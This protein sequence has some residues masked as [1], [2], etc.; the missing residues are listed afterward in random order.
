MQ[1]HQTYACAV[2][3]RVDQVVWI[4]RVFMFFFYFFGQLCFYSSQRN[5]RS[6]TFAQFFRISCSIFGTNRDWRR[7]LVNDLMS[8]SICDSDTLTLVSCITVRMDATLC[9]AL[10]IENTE[11]S[12]RDLSRVA[13]SCFFFRPHAVTLSQWRTVIICRL[14]NYDNR[15]IV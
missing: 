15:T 12:R 1:Q 9:L 11:G 6:L 14:F 4:P 2:C 10:S 13:F 8:I 5:S 3:R 7:R